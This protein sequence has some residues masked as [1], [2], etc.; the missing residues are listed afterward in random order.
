MPDHIH[1]SLNNYSRYCMEISAYVLD[2]TTQKEIIVKGHSSFAFEPIT[3]S[4]DKEIVEG[5]IFVALKSFEAHEF[6]EWYKYKGVCV[7]DPH[8]SVKD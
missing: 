3:K 7:I 6:N 5:I 8:P 4:S 2:V 1:Q